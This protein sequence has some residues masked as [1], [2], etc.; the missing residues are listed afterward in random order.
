MPRNLRNRTRGD[1]RSAIGY[2]ARDVF[3][4]DG[5]PYAPADRP[6]R[7]AD[8]EIREAADGYVAYDPSTDRLHFLNGTAAFVLEA[9]DGQTRVDEVAR[10]VEAA[11]RLDRAPAAEV[12][13]LL[14]RFAAE[15]LIDGTRQRGR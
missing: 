2:D 7:K 4:H 3:E 1:G 5:M 6:R 10:L 14:A 8:L 13:A 9:L 15:G 11:F 12:D